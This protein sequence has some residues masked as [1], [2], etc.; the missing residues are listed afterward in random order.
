[1]SP[2]A[3]WLTRNPAQPVPFSI[4]ARGHQQGAVEAAART[5]VANSIRQPSLSANP[6]VLNLGAIVGGLFASY[7]A[8][9]SGGAQRVVVTTFILAA[10]MLVLLPL[11]LPLVALLV[12][13]AIAGVGTIGTQVLIYGLVSNYYPTRARAAGVA[14]CAGFGRLGGIVGPMVGGLLVGVGVGGSAAFLIIAGLAVVGAAVTAFV[15]RSQTASPAPTAS[16]EAA[17]ATTM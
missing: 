10:A 8:D 15:P 2:P 12:A 14:W 3:T 13:V 6:S 1:L 5:G 17:V 11:R 4:P 9:R 16:V 7:V